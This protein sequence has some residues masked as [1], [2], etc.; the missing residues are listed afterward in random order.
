MADR[1]RFAVSATPI[2]T[3]TDENN[4]SH[5]ILASEVKTKLGGGGDSFSLAAYNQTAA[6][7][8]Y[9]NATVN[10]STATYSAGG[11]QLTALA[12]ADFIFIKN[13]G[14]RFSNATTL[15]EASTDIVIVALKTAGYEN[16]VQS[17]WYTQGDQSQD[18]F[19]EIAWLQPGQAIALPLGCINKSVTQFGSNIGDF[20]NFGSTSQNGTA[21]IFVK[22]V[23]SAGVLSTASNAVEYLAVS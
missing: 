9:L 5:D 12:T 19:F 4:A 3:I 23:T 22:T 14:F 2:E 8:G 6:A 21:Q 17:G 7:Q 11:T 10:Y 13:T 1:I 20:S 16:G 18:H 15:G